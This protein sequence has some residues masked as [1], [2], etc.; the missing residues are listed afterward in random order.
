MDESL[1][2]E[3]LDQWGLV[4]GEPQCAQA[5]QDAGNAQAVV[6]VSA[7]EQKIQEGTVNLS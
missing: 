1:F 5:L 2:Q 3:E 4:V 6:C 7:M